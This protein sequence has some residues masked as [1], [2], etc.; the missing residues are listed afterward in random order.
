MSGGIAPLVV[1]FYDEIWN[2]GDLAAIP[3]LLHEAVTFRGSLAE[4]RRG[5]DGFAAYVV[6]IRG[7][8]DN[9]RC[10]IEDLVCEDDRAFARMAFSGIHRGELLA[11]PPTGRRVAWAGAVLFTGG[12]DGRIGDIWALGDVAGLRVQL[13][14][15]GPVNPSDRA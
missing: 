4:E 2:R 13:A 3:R 8:L 12:P 6:M 9:Y 15:E 7:A 14:G 1:A 5:H 11:F 10:D